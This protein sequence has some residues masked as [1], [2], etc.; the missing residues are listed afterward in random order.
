MTKSDERRTASETTGPQPL[1]LAASRAI[2]TPLSEIGYGK[3]LKTSAALAA[4]RPQDVDHRVGES[5]GRISGRRPV[6]QTRTYFPDKGAAY[7]LVSEVRWNCPR[8]HLSEAVAV[9]EAAFR[10]APESAIASALLKLRL[11]TQGRERRDEATQEAEATLWIE[12]LRSYPGDIVLD[13]LATWHKRDDG[14][15]WPAWK[16]VQDEIVY[17]C[18]RRQALLNKLREIE[19]KPDTKV[20]ED[21]PPTQEQR[22]RAFAH[23]EDMKKG[24]QTADE[25]KP[26][27]DPLE[28]LNRIK[29]EGWGPIAIGSDLEAKLE[30]MKGESRP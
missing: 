21:F 20:I 2:G 16:D 10:S 28:T 27:E 9:I 14:R 22:D 4:M 6:F 23:W 1:A 29:A 7:S 26:Q 15:W 24:F 12:L 8:E 25:P 13:V 5:L 19:A 3:P 18:D 11:T 17:R 30:A